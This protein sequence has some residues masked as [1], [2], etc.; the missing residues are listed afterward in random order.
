MATL[1][2]LT[3]RGIPVQDSV[4]C[5]LLKD[6]TAS[7]LPRLHSCL[8]D[9]FITICPGLLFSPQMELVIFNIAVFFSL[10]WQVAYW[11]YL[12]GISFISYILDAISQ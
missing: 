3:D 6:S 4:H 2:S 8:L 11:K 7:A 1:P 5:I 12:L 9:V 10:L